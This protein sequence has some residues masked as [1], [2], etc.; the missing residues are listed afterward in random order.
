MLEHTMESNLFDYELLKQSE[1][2]AQKKFKDSNY[3]GEI[4]DRKRYGLGIMA[5]FNGRLYE[6]EWIEDRRHGRGYEKFSNG[7]MY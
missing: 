7:N 6:G 2:F 1:N 3:M 5:Y 4:K